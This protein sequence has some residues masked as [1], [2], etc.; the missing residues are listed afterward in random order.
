M[1]E[2]GDLFEV[3]PV[4]RGEAACIACP[5]KGVA[6]V[7]DVKRGSPRGAWCNRQHSGL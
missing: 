7:D 3:K 2:Q 5:W 6:L 1:T 4:I